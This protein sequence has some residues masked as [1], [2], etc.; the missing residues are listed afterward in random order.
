ME[1]TKKINFTED[2]KKI[3]AINSIKK[4]ESL[5]DERNQK[6]AKKA[7]NQNIIAVINEIL[8]QLAYKKELLLEAAE[9]IFDFFNKRKNNI[10]T[11]YIATYI[12]EKER[13][14]TM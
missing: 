14:R 1:N 12:I 6:T 13:N 11:D 3:N 2:F 4:L 5:M 7:D 10:I 9:T 8:D